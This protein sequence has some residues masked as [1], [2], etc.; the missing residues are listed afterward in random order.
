MPSGWILVPLLGSFVQA[1]L[2][3]LHSVCTEFT[4]STPYNKAILILKQHMYW[5]KKFLNVSLSYWK[6][7][8]FLIQSQDRRILVIVSITF[9][10]HFSFT[11][12]SP[13]FKHDTV[14]T[15]YTLKLHT[16][17]TVVSH[18]QI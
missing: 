8:T 4:G 10:L 11:Q 7:F 13:N 17:Y 2:Q 15:H 12:R 16:I 9:T 1:V 3:T 6:I 5:I 14:F 18:F